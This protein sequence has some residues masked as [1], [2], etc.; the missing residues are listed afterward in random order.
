MGDGFVSTNEMTSFFF[1]ADVGSTSVKLLTSISPSVL[2]MA[3]W[4]YSSEH[5]FA[6][7][8]AL[9]AK[10]L[11]LLLDKK[12]FLLVSSSSSVILITAKMLKETGRS[13]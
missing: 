4:F 10:E 9:L 7:E 11:T 12:E 6:N 5:C 2:K 1:S 13:V 3:S 8:F